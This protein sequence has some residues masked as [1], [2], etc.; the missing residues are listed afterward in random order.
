MAEF[1]VYCPDCDILYPELVVRMESRHVGET[2]CPQGHHIDVDMLP[3]PDF[4]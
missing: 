2:E 4:S 1:A 3:D